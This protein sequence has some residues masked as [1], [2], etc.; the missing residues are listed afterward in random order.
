MTDRSPATIS[1]ISP[2]HQRLVEAARTSVSRDR[3]AERLRRIV[4]LPSPTGDEL[5]LARLLADELAA[6]GCEASVQAIDDRQG[7]AVGRLAGSGGGVDLLLYAPL[8]TAFSGD[9]AEDEPWLG[10]EPR[11]DLALPARIDGGKVIGLGAENPKSYIACILEVV[12]ALAATGADLPGSLT[13]GF[14]GGGMPT[15]GRPG[16]RG[17]IGHG[18]GSAYM[19]EHGVT[20]DYAIIVKPGY[21][22]SWE[23]VGISWHTITIRG[24][25]NYAGIRHRVPYRNPIV[26]AANVIRALE[27]WFPEFTARHSDGLVSPQGSI[28]A[29]RGGGPDLAAYVPPT[30]ELFVDLRVSPR[31]TPAE[32]HAEL[33][34]HL[35]KVREENPDFE[36]ASEMTVGIGGTSTPEDSWIVQSLVRAWEAQEGRPHEPARGTSGAT[37]AAILRGHGIETARIGPPLPKTPSPYPGFSMGQADLDSMETLVSVLLRAVVDTIGRPRSEIVT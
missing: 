3:M 23:E 34:E 14:A 17:N 21:A 2:Q 8:D 26:A 19:L 7:N 12:D 18:A 13:A 35:A 36:I 37:D 15:S 31:S 16:R 20:P 33:E 30:C 27:A 6:M 4:D 28:G 32:V 1:S 25:L 22:V 9:V 29:I 24:A 11:P 10:R 5:P